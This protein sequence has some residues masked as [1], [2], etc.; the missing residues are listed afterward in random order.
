MTIQSEL[1][2]ERNNYVRDDGFRDTMPKVI[3]TTEKIERERSWSPGLDGYRLTYEVSI[4]FYACPATYDAAQRA[5]AARIME[6]AYGDVLS[7]LHVAHSHI[8]NGDRY[9]ALATLDKMKSLMTY[10]E[11]G[12][13]V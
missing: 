12:R 5:A 7:L 3:E 13:R 8:F 9:E 6:I 2:V 1:K 4:N 10:V 11:K